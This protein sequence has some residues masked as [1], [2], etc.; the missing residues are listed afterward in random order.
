MG[1]FRRGWRIGRVTRLA[2]DMRRGCGRGA[3]VAAHPLR[4]SRPKRKSC[5]SPTP[6][7]LQYQA[8]R[9]AWLMQ[10]LNL[11]YGRSAPKREVVMRYLVGLVCLLALG[12]MPVMGCTDGGAISCEDDVD[13]PDDNNACTEDYCENNGLCVYM[14]VECTADF[15]DCTVEVCDPA[16]GCQQ[17]PVADGTKCDGVACQAGDCELAG[18]VLPC[19]ELGIRNAIDAGVDDSEVERLLRLTKVAA[20]HVTRVGRDAV[21]FAW[22]SSG[23]QGI[24]NPS[25]LQRCFRDM[26]VGAGHMVFDDRN[27]IELAKVRLGLDAA[28]F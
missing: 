9:L 22:Q 13:C 23:S 5:A 28:P 26:H 2:D 1:A 18:S 19:S 7:P 10:L 11:S 17:E 20:N 3:A 16:V 12:F 25:R 8:R 4:W 6:I 24:R 27:Y 21:D 15:N 14:P